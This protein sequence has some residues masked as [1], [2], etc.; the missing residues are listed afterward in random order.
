MDAMQGKFITFEG[1]EGSGKSTQ[2]QL[3]KESLQAKGIDVIVTRE[4]GGTPDA[5][6]IR[7][8]LVSG[9]PNRWD[10][11]TE[12]LLMFAA[13][14]DHLVKKIWPA[15]KNGTW[16][17]SDRF[18]DSSMAYQGFA[19]GIGQDQVQSIY[20]LVVG[21]YKPD[22]TIILDIDPEIGLNRAGTRAVVGDKEDRFEKMGSSFHKK[23]RTAFLDIARSNPERCKTFQANQSIENLS[24]QIFDKVKFL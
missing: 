21:D 22:L 1:G 14:R 23:I 13:R 4:P 3:L 19:H 8:L 5:E 15:I 12:L 2:I 16:V 11:M 6:Q 10:P 20:D 7:T 9:E 18:A 24:A 17:L